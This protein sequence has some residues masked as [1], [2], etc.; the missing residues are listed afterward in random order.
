MAGHEDDSLASASA[1]R[2]REFLE[3]KTMAKGVTF[4]VT[5][6]DAVGNVSVADARGAIDEPP[7]IDHV[8]IDPPMVPSGGLARVTIVAR[9]PEN[10]AL[11]FEIRASEG[12]LEPTSEP[13]V[14]LWRAP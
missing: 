7:I 4:S 8:I 10:D 13:N 9:D 12:T 14:F 1:G 3:G 6:R 5:V 11:T 2:G